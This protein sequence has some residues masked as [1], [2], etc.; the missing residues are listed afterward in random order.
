[1]QAQHEL[2]LANVHCF[3][4]TEIEVLLFGNCYLRKDMQS[5]DLAWLPLG[6]RAR[7]TAPA[8]P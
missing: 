7:L 3:M 4:G 6:V 1:M 2:Q 8:M 5:V